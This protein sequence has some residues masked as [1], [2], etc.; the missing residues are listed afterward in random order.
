MC[1]A[2][3]DGS[4]G[5]RPAAAA[6][7]AACASGAV[8][9]AALCSARNCH[10]R[11]F[12]SLRSK[13]GAGSNPAAFTNLFGRPPRVCWHAWC[14]LTAVPPQ[15]CQPYWGFAPF[16]LLSTG[17][18]TSNRAGWEGWGLLQGRAILML[19]WPGWG[20]HK[21]GALPVPSLFPVQRP[22][23]DS[24][25][26]A[27]GTARFHGRAPRAAARGVAWRPAGSARQ[28]SPTHCLQVPVTAGAARRSQNGRTSM[29]S[30]GLARPAQATA[31]RQTACAASG[32]QVGDVQRGAGP[33]AG[34]WPAAAAAACRQLGRTAAAL[35]QPFWQSGHRF[36]ATRSLLD[37]AAAMHRCQRHASTQQSPRSGPTLCR[38]L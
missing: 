6:G 32:Q 33:A 11:L 21:G 24:R 13:G 14:R 22:P 31:R 5:S 30:T 19:A 28:P 20:A 4:G 35:L 7:P 2:A 3:E 25:R 36:A 37:R 8:P 12:S 38:R 10:V 1:G 18:R 26:D 23:P 17:L 15:P 34:G 16:V 27:A 9:S 29:A